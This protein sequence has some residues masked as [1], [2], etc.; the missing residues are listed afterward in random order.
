MTSWFGG[1]LP[2]NSFISP[3]HLAT[4]RHHGNVI[5]CCAVNSNI[6][7]FHLSKLWKATFFIFCVF[8]FLVRLQWKFETDHS[9]ELSPG[10]RVLPTQ[11]NSS[12]VHNF[13]GVGIVWPPTWLELARVGSS[14]LEFDQAQIFAQL[15]PSFPPFGHHSILKPT[16]AKLFW[17][18]MWLCVHIPTSEWFLASWLDLAVP[19][20]HPPM[21]VLIL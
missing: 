15:E 4:K 1:P 17:V 7:I 3:D 11:A 5:F 9:W 2:F 14:W 13:D 10:Q 20:G 16:L 21:Q 6:T 19:F 8:I 18:G 12:Q